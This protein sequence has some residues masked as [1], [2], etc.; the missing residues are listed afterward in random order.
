MP[1]VLVATNMYPSPGD[2]ARGAF[3][4]AQVDAL[5][6]L[7][8]PV[9]LF[10][11]HGDRRAFNYA[12]AIRPLRAAVHAFA[13]DLVYA[14][15]GLTGWIALWQPSPVV[16]SLAGDDILGTPDRH[17]GVTAKS[18]V[19]VVL[20]QW[21]AHRAAVVCVQSE[22]MR[23]RL[24]GAGLRRRALV[25]PYGVDPGRFHPGDQNEARRRLGLPLGPPLVIFPN[26]PTEPRKRLDL[27]SKA[28]D[29]VGKEWPG[30]RLQIV[31]G[32]PHDDMPDYYRAADCCLLTSDWEGSPNVVK[33]ALLCGLP[34][35]TTDVGDVGRWVPLSPEC[36][37][38]GRTPEDLAAGVRR[39]LRERRRVDPG[40]FLA[41]FSSPAVAARM[42]QLFQNLVDGRASR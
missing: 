2:P 29:L 36:S 20:S 35:V 10:A 3:V 39:V 41:G 21:A 22:E 38:C 32:V 13:A 6:A 28:M 18:R 15:Y 1:R 40:P 4:R 24:W 11:V 12:R 31:S 7:D 33:E 27:A 17:G 34:V 30:V 14:F 9:E 26:T 8:V 42:L 19:G 25:V 16:L 37:I 23:N 5:R